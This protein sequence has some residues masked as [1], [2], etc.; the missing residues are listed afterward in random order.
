MT[1]SEWAKRIGLK[2]CTIY[3][4]INSG[5]TAHQALELPLYSSIKGGAHAN[6]V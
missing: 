4:R 5:W 6:A 1:V 2:A 3:Y